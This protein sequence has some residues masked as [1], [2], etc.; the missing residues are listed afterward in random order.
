MPSLS[1]I[2][3]SSS[4]KYLEAD[5]TQ[6]SEISNQDFSIDFSTVEGGNYPR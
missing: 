2:Y 6:P 3:I 1:Q 4:F 5:K